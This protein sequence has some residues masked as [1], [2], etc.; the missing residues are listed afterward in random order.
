MGLK[1]SVKSQVVKMLLKSE[2]KINHLYQDSEGNITVGIGHLVRK[3]DQIS[4][5]TMYTV[6]DDQPGKLASQ[7]QKEEE[8]VK[9]GKQTKRRPA[10]WYRQF[11]TLMMKRSDIER[12]FKKDLDSFYVDLTRRYKKSNGF[13]KKFDDFP[14]KVQMALFDMIFNLGATKLRKLFTEFHKAIAREDWAKAAEESSRKKIGPDR[15]SYVKG[16][17]NA[18]SKE[19]KS[20]ARK[21]P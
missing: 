1:A 15:N 3:K 2:D 16:L 5:V 6:V 17:F 18:A 19:Q 4:V 10:I 20:K 14:D 8:H 9:I 12:L 11:T 7:K 13:S 21:K